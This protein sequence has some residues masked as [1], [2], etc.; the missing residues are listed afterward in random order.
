MG[1]NLQRVKTGIGLAILFFVFF[2]LLFQFVNNPFFDSDEGDIFSNGAA[3]AN[4]YNLYS[5]ATSQHMPFTY[6]FSA[7]FWALGAQTIVTQRIVF[8]GLFAALW[9]IIYYRYKSD[10]GKI[11]LIAYPVL[12]SFAISLYDWGAAILSEHLAGIGFVILALE[13][14]RFCKR[15][16]VDI[17][18]CIAISF[19]IVLTFGTIF[20][21]AYG[22]A[23]VAVFVF[24]K[25]IQ[26]LIN[27]H[28][29]VKQWLK[30]CL[31][32]LAKLAFWCLL[33]WVCLLIIYAING[34]LEDA[35]YYAYTFNRTVY[36]NYTGGYGSNAIEGAVSG[37]NNL[38]VLFA[39]Y[40]G[41]ALSTVSWA[42]IILGCLALMGI[43]WHAVKHQVVEASFFTILIIALATRGIW[44]F[45]GGQCVA[46]LCFLAAMAISFI[47]HEPMQ[48]IARSTIGLVL[49]ICIGI[50]AMPYSSDFTLNMDLAESKTKAS[51]IIDALTEEGEPVF[52][53]K[54]SNNT[55][56]IQSKTVPFKSMAV[57]WFTDVC[58]EEIIA[59]YPDGITRVV[60]HDADQNVWGLTMKDYAPELCAYIER[61]YTR[62]YA[63][64]YVRNDVYDNAVQI[65]KK[66]ESSIFDFVID[67]TPNEDEI[68]V[69][70]VKT[71]DG[72][73]S[74]YYAVW[75]AEAGQDDLVFYPVEV[76]AEG[77][78][79]T[80]VD[81][82]KHLL[83]TQTDTIMLL[84]YGGNGGD[85]D[86]IGQDE[87][88]AALVS[89]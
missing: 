14:L 33:P 20:V 68:T 77:N 32:L 17:K 24:V 6:Y 5:E 46:I 89:Q 86:L 70:I 10:V 34:N 19:A 79:S 67:R 11:T 22:V 72:Y 43:I 40:L 45:H 66:K 44:T 21:A 16:T 36:I 2:G 83:T 29:P 3:I 1:K 88:V 30:D 48:R 56:L 52:V 71:P 13:F 81:L 58:A 27:E 9:C 23:T 12:F 74:V 64:I 28:Q 26:W 35:F 84:A 39:S 15:K 59:T 41:G 7:L 65:I 54:A 63:C 55:E 42:E 18:S 57:P 75:S 47:L 60:L 25:E 78:Y 37:F 85:M 73:Q 8:Y 50:V 51:K 38:K 31:L 61:N 4:G 49:V 87:Y 53:T 69:T 80:T 76:N 82:S 62:L